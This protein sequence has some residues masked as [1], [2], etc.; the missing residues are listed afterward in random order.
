M[1]LER[2]QN[3]TDRLIAGAAGIGAGR[4]LGLT[5]EE[6]IATKKATLRREQRQRRAQRGQRE[7]N[8]AAAEAFLAQEDAKFQ[9]NAHA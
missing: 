2:R 5:D 4:T 9:Q 7:G 3:A 6:T 8:R 1:T